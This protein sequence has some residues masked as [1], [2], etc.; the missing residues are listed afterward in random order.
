MHWQQLNCV[1]FLLYPSLR[2]RVSRRLG[3]FEFFFFVADLQ[4]VQIEMYMTRT[5]G[6]ITCLLP[7]FQMCPFEDVFLNSLIKSV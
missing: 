4:C 6:T 7:A 5:A 1:A 3:G 2:V